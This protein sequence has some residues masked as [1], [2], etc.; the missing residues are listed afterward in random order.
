MNQSSLKARV[1]CLGAAAVLGAGLVLTATMPAQA[2]QTWSEQE[3]HHGVNTF[4][5][6]HNA[7]G[8]GP[9]ID[10]AAWVQVSCKVYDPYIQSVN[11]D[12]YWYRIASS[13]WNDAYYS[14]ANTFMNGDPWDG[15]YT[16]NTDFSVPDC[17]S[18]PPPPPPP[19][20]SVT[21]AQGPTAPEGYRY[22]ITLNNFAS[23]AGIGISCYDSASAAFYQFTLNTDGSGHAFTQS[24]CYSNDGPG[25]WV[26]A[27]GVESNHVSW[28]PRSSGGGGG[29]STGSGSSSSGSSSQT[30]GGGTPPTGQTS[31]PAPPRSFG[32]RRCAGDPSGHI[33]EQLSAR[34]DPEHDGYK[35]TIKPGDKGGVSWYATI[36][37][38]T[39]ATNDMWD[40]VRPCVADLPLSLTSS[41]STS[42][43]Y[44]LYCHFYDQRG[45]WLPFNNATFAGTYDLETWRPASVIPKDS[46]DRRLFYVT[47]GCNWDE[48][49]D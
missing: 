4:Q 25:H 45:I 44:Q 22:A 5:N 13:P 40:I 43:Y 6:Y 15:P 7:S 3:G 38:V 12:G 39:D 21:L 46:L 42:V 20:P 26:I 1:I 8:M 36:G 11:P 23:N 47:T 18:T 14:P 10:P 34:P 49:S 33:V 19:S 17:G 35:I 30:G 41:Q 28:G 9:R 37:K 32:S 27:N 29:Q 24:Y 48:G 2:E 31:A 16:H